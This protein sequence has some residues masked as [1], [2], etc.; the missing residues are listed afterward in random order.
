LFIKLYAYFWYGYGFIK[1]FINK[2][3]VVID[4]LG[5]LNTN[6]FNFLLT[7]NNKYVPIA[8][9][10]ENVTVS[11][12]FHVALYPPFILIDILD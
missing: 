1:L 2:L 7:H 9:F 12:L 10:Y 5:I 3:V 6:L 4:L 8:L 11:I